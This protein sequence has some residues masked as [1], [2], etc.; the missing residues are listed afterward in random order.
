VS[1]CATPESVNYLRSSLGA[2]FE[3]QSLSIDAQLLLSKRIYKKTLETEENRDV[4]IEVEEN[5]DLYT[6]VLLAAIE[7]KNVNITEH[8]INYYSHLL[9]EL[10]FKHQ[11][12]ISTTAFESKQLDILCYL[13]D[14][15]DFPFPDNFKMPDPDD[16]ERLFEIARDRVDFE[17][18]IKEERFEKLTNFIIENNYP[19]HIYNLSNESAIRQAIKIKNY[20]LCF[21][22]QSHGLREL[23]TSDEQKKLRQFALRERNQNVEQSLYDEKNSV[24]LLCTRSS[25]HNRR[26]TKEQKEIYR[27]KIKQWY[28]AIYNARFGPEFLNAVS[29]CDEIKIIFDFNSENVRIFLSEDYF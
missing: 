15:L 26:I 23:L 3:S 11:V 18:D 24:N 19:K 7:N 5:S 27:K 6:S 29:T 13:L 12:R 14:I 1:K 22:L 28:T 17:S 8:L 4:S 21:H 2:S 25:L 9:Q 16:N 20:A 10:P